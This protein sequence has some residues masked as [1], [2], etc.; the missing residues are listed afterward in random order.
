LFVQAYVLI[1]AIWLGVTMVFALTLHGIAYGETAGE[2]QD[3]EEY[4][5]KAV[6]RNEVSFFILYFYI[7]P[8]IIIYL[9][10]CVCSTGIYQLI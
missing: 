2:R 5:G 1:A 6:E 7:S 9:Y 10:M 8:S 4:R 3:N